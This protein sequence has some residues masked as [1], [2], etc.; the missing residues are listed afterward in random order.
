MY[1]SKE[2]KDAAIAMAVDCHL[3]NG[4][5]KSTAVRL[6]KDEFSFIT[7]AAVYQALRRYQNRKEASYDKQSS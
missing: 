7:E 1:K 4:V 2:E 6:V 3:R 5:K